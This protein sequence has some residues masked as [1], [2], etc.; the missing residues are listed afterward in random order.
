MNE[1]DVTIIKNIKLGKQKLQVHSHIF[2]KES[3]AI[4]SI[5]LQSFN[6]RKSDFVSL[7]SIRTL[8]GILVATTCTNY[9]FDGVKVTY[10]NGNIGF[11]I[12]LND[13]I[14][15]EFEQIGIEKVLQK[16]IDNY[17]EIYLRIIKSIEL[18]NIYNAL[19]LLAKNTF[20][21]DKLEKDITETLLK[22]QDIAKGK[23]DELSQAIGDSLLKAVD[24]NKKN[25]SNKNID[26]KL[27]TP[28]KTKK[29][30]TKKK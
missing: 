2:F 1:Y 16:E 8:Y 18:Q 22:M 13:R 7:M 26:E 27:D 28:T 12:N 10:E 11:N 15:N 23:P 24:K 6:Q 5:C 19:D 20:N 29:T 17:E 21:G 3:M 4:A 9:S 25:K 30:N 14:I